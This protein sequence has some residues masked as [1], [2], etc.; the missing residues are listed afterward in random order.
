M[1]DAK[2]SGKEIPDLRL[3]DH[4]SGKRGIE[5]VEACLRSDRLRLEAKPYFI[6]PGVLYSF[7][8]RRSV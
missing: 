8:T 2:I 3:P 5:L 4:Q 1:L 6:A 7:T